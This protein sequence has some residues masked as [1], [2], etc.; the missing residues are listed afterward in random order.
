[1]SDDEAEQ[2]LRC[3]ITAH[4]SLT[5]MIS[6]VRMDQSQP[7]SLS[8]QPL[9]HIIGQISGRRPVQLTSSGADWCEEVV[10]T[11][12]GPYPE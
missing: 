7:R 1:M 9:S 2:S 10:A 5:T 12:N 8:L 4:L 6:H 11:F 3:T